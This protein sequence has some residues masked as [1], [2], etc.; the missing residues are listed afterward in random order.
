[1]VSAPLHSSYL[2]QCRVSAGAATG[3][4]RAATYCPT[5]WLRPSLRGMGEMERGNGW[6]RYAAP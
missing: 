5:L 1:M 4:I 3:T 2:L 6:N